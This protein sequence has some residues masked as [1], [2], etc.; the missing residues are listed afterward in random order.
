VSTETRGKVLVRR[1]I[2]VMVPENLTP[3]SLVATYGST[4]RVNMRVGSRELGE[5]DVSFR[6]NEALAGR[7][8]LVHGLHSLEANKQSP[9]KSTI[10]YAI[11]NVTLAWK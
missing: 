6:A 7:L 8:V 5:R 2:A 4:N 9:T 10:R 3:L 1:L 11:D